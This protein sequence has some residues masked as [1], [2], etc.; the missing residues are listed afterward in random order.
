MILLGLALAGC[1]FGKLGETPTPPASSPLFASTKTDPF[2]RVNQGRLTLDGQAFIGKG[3]N[4]Y[5]SWTKDLGLGPGPRNGDAGPLYQFNIFVF[6]R[7]FDPRAIDA[8]MAFLR[9]QLGATMIRV[10]LPAIDDAEHLLLYH[11]FLPFREDTGHITSAF[12]QKVKT[13]ADIALKQGIR[14]QLS[15]MWSVH[16]ELAKDPGSF[17]PGK[18]KDIYY[19][20]WVLSLG[21]AVADHPGVMAFEISNESLVHWSLNGCQR[22]SFEAQML[23]FT[24]RRISDFRQVAPNQLIGSAEVSQMHDF[25][26]PSCPEPW[27]FPAPE[28]A[29]LEDV[30]NING[31]Q[32]FSLASRVDYFAGHFYPSTI[33][34]K[35]TD[36]EFEAQLARDTE[37]YR[38]VAEAARAYGLPLIAGEFGAVTEPGN[39]ERHLLEPRQARFFQSALDAMMANGYQGVLAW[40]AVPG[41]RLLPGQHQV[42]PSTLNPW[43]NF[44]LRTTDP[45]NLRTTIFYLPN[46]ETFRFTT[47]GAIQ[48]NE[49]GLWLKRAWAQSQPVA[50]TIVAPHH[51]AEF[52]NFTSS[53]VLKWSSAPSATGGYLVRVADLTDP[54]ARDPRNNGR[55]L[56]YLYLNNYSGTEVSLPVQPGHRYWFWIHSARADFSYEDTSSYSREAMIEF[57]VQTAPPPDL[58]ITTI[59]SP[60]DGTVFSPDTTAV[61]LS[62]QGSGSNLY[63]VRMADLTDPSLRHPILGSDGCAYVCTGVY[64]GTDIHVPVLRGHSY[65]FWIHAVT[66]NFSY[67]DPTTVGPALGGN[68]LVAP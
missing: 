36:A 66:A 13:L 53:V 29:V 60:A 42:V 38:R 9:Q 35:R 46:F 43:T 41:M 32:P 49:A 23:S 68:F 57:T 10:P 33:N 22:S 52:G 6:W 1:S 37:G 14:I 3:T 58:N 26:G 50:P 51:R 34:L 67:S 16:D 48:I 15:A 7:E 25:T 55:N 8:D 20:N 11:N 31:G 4:Y 59:F 30:H 40:G 61:Q 56:T 39:L 5:G 17:E 63:L 2:V 27:F 24:A 54:N 12:A 64:S 28:F 65:R 21:Q 18:P 19:K 62:W 47:D 44:E 45:G